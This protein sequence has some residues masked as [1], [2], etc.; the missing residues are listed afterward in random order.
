MENFL[1]LSTKDYLKPVHLQL[2]Q[3]LACTAIITY[4]GNHT[5]IFVVFN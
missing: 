4:E 2:H 1:R 5:L 3:T